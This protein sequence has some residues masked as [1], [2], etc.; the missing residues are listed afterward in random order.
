MEKSDGT[1]VFIEADTVINAF[2]MKP[3]TTVGKAISDKFHT[4]T[5]HVKDCVSIGKVGNAVRSGF[6]AGLTLE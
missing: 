3:N 5:R 1:G 4:K 6:F 2:G